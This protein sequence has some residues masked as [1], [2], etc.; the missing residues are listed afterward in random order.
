MSGY[1][2]N[3]GEPNP[4]GVTAKGLGHNF[5]LFSSSADKIILAIFRPGDDTPLFEVPLNKTE[6][7]WHIFVDKLPTPFEYAYKINDVYLLDPYAKELDSPHRWETEREDYRPK[8]VVTPHAEVFSWAGEGRPNAPME[9]LVIYE[10]HVRAFTQDPSSKA[11]HPGT[12]LGVIEKI[13]YLKELGVNAVELMPLCEFN[14]AEYNAKDPTTGKKLCNFWGYSTINFFSATNRYAEKHTINEFKTMVK[15]L[16]KHGIEVILDMVYNHTGEG[17][18]GDHK[19]LSFRG[20]DKDAYYC[21]NKENV[22]VD[23]TGT[24]NTVNCNHPAVTKMIIESLRYW[25]T[26]MH[27]DG[28]RFDLASIFSRD[29]DGTPLADPPVLKAMR[30]DPILSK[31]KLIAESWDAGGLYQVG[32][33]PGWGPWSEWNG[34][35][36]DNVRKFIKGSDNMTGAFATALSGSQ[37]LYGHY[38]DGPVHS[39]NFVT[40]HDGF[41]LADLVSYQGKHNERNGEENRDGMND[42]ESWNCGAEGPTKNRKILQLRERQARNFYLALFVSLGV[43]MIVMGDEY[44]HT[45]NGNNNTWCQ[46]NSLNWMNWNNPH[47]AFTRFVRLL[48]KLRKHIPI[49]SRTQFFSNDD[50]EWHGHDPHQ[51]NWSPES[52]FVAYTIKDEHH[53]CYIAFNAFYYPAP[54]TLPPPPPHKKWYRVIDT[55]LPSPEDFLEHP[56][57]RKPVKNNYSLYSYS[58]LLLIAK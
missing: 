27:V 29:K 47:P 40:A 6:D 32:G 3:K 18:F 26:E 22:P 4:L 51:P 57:E 2:T 20:I 9:K 45:K 43:P 21:H 44:L 19:P 36:R 17:G 33:F 34:K 38:N 5:A 15:E 16:H 56:E 14:E 39:I 25:V 10:M 1:K 30:E 49:F 48:I 55:S 58:A 12:F 37:D 41:S 35:F 8:G 11:A 52:R 42:N 7:H 31:V 28:F 50:V 23:F 54:L 13:P 53:T 24:G 46:D